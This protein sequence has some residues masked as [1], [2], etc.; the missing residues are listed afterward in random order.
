MY[1]YSITNHALLYGH[2]YKV[3]H[4]LDLLGWPNQEGRDGSV[5]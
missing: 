3:H 2:Q 4:I 1:I 5:T